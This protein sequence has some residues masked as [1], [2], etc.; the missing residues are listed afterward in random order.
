META[1]LL[2]NAGSLFTYVQLVIFATHAV[3]L[4]LHKQRVHMAV[5]GLLLCNLISVALGL[6][7]KWDKRSMRI[8]S[9]I[10]IAVSVFAMVVYLLS[11]RYAA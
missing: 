6:P 2:Y 3:M 8:K 5:L 7:Y 4:L 9:F 11:F 1:E 10:G